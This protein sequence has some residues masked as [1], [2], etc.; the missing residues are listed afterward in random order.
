[1][2]LEITVVNTGDTSLNNITIVQMGPFA[3]DV[4]QENPL[5]IP[6]LSVGASSISSWN[7]STP[8]PISPDTIMGKL[9]SPMQLLVSA[10]NESEEAVRPAFSIQSIH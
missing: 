10:V 7:I 8:Y 2:T 4:N 9:V 1:M 5:V 3:Q 6:S